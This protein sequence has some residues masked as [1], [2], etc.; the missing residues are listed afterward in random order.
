MIMKKIVRRMLQMCPGAWY[1]FISAVKLTSFLLVCAF[2][3]L[4]AWDGN[5]AEGFTK[6][7]TAMA[8]YETGQ[9]VLLVGVLFSAL[10]EDVQA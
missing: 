7:M 9:A 6:Y 1:I 5:M 4:L 2:M 10:I 8:L 3:L